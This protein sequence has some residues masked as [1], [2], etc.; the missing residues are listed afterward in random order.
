MCVLLTNVKLIPYQ[1][2]KDQCIKTSFVTEVMCVLR[3]NV[4]LI[5]YQHFKDQCIPD[6]FSH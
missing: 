4:I 2:Y 5:S 3:I 6:K 1:H